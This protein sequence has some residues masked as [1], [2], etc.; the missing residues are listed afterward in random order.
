VIILPVILPSALAANLVRTAFAEAE[1]TAARAGVGLCTRW[2]EHV[3]L[4]SVE[5]EPLRA[6]A[7]DLVVAQVRIV[8]W[9]TS[10]RHVGSIAEQA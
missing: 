2:R 4:A 10:D 6:T 8:V 9:S 5:L 3:A 1:M 7:H